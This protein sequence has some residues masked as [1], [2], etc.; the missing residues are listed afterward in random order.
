MKSLSKCTPRVSRLS[1]IVEERAR[2]TSF[3]DNF[4]ASNYLNSRAILYSSPYARARITRVEAAA[5]TRVYCPVGRCYQL[6]VTRHQFIAVEG[7]F[8]TLPLPRYVRAYLHTG[9]RVS[10]VHPATTGRKA[11]FD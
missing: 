11:H 6:C 4:L 8:H 7:H 1:V 10:Q 2:Q 9:A 5:K 3:S